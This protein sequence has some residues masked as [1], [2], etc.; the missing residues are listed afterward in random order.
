MKA[1]NDNYGLALRLGWQALCDH[2]HKEDRQRDA[3]SGE[4]DQRHPKPEGQQVYCELSDW[5]A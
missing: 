2:E 4:P 3:R 5:V 1:N